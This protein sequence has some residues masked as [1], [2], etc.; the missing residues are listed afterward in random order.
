MWQRYKGLKVFN[1]RQRQAL[2][3]HSSSRKFA[4][5][6]RRSSS[7]SSTMIL[8]ASVHECKGASVYKNGAKCWVRGCNVQ[9]RS[10][11]N[12]LL[13]IHYSPL[14]TRHSLPFYHLPFTFANSPLAIRCRFRLGRSLALPLFAHRLKSVATKRSPLMQAERL[15]GAS[16]DAPN[17]SAVREH[18]PPDKIIRHSLPFSFC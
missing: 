17:F 5:Q 13:A 4:D 1:C 12:S 16:P 14:A 3:P 2:K 15:E 10:F 6:S 8:R 7:P 18:C 9:C 11:A